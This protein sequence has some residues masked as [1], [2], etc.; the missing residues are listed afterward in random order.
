[1]L[2]ERRLNAGC[3]CLFVLFGAYAV[4]RSVRGGENLANPQAQFSL[5][6]PGRRRNSVGGGPLG[7]AGGA[8]ALPRP[9]SRNQEGPTSRFKSPKGQTNRREELG[10]AHNSPSLNHPNAVTSPANGAG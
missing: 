7:P 9:P 10:D 8:L 2:S 6:S 5:Q 3:P 1:M 4:G